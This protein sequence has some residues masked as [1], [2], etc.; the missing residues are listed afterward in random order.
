MCGIVGFSGK[1][2][3][4]TLNKMM[5][6]IFHR[7]PDDGAKLEENSFSIGFRRLAI[8]DLSKN[9]YPI[10]NENEDIFVFLNGET[11]AQGKIMNSMYISENQ[12]VIGIARKSNTSPYYK[13]STIIGTVNSINGASINTF[14]LL[15]E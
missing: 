15:D 7:G 1:P 13:A 9:I 4:E 10:K 8:V 11:D 2:E 5:D 6:S 14:M 3:P 12:P